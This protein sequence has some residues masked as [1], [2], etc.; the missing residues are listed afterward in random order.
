MTHLNPGGLGTAAPPTMISRLQPSPSP[1]LD[2]KGLRAGIASRRQRL[3]DLE[4][5]LVA[6]CE[7][8]AA[9]SRASSVRMDDRETWD[10]DTW[11][12]YLAAAANLEPEYGPQMRRLLREIDQLARLAELPV[13]MEAAA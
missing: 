12:R 1:H 3:L 2:G 11:T 10:R 6:G 8:E 5:A 9:R 4:A 7:T 13:A